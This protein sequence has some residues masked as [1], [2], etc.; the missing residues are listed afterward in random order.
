MNLC[1][2]LRRTASEIGSYCVYPFLYVH[3]AVI[4][5]YSTLCC[6]LEQYGD[7][8]RKHEELCAAYNTLHGK[9]ITLH[10]TATYAHD[11]EKE[12]EWFRKRFDATTGHI[13]PVMGVHC[14]ER[15]H[16]MLIEGG[17][18]QGFEKDMIVLADNLL[19]GKIT[20]VYPWYSVVQLITDPA[21]CVSVC[22]VG[23]GAHG[24]VRG[25]GS[26]EILHLER[27]D[28]LSPV[29]EQELL[30]S[31]GDGLVVPR[32]Y[33]VG[34]VEQY[35]SDGLYYTG[36]VKVLQRMADLKTCLVFDRNNLSKRS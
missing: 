24:I 20:A 1:G 22:G 3:T 10:A 33:G 9:Y 16:T 32:G 7:L 15:Q 11:V 8:L 27:V 23:S 5:P 19:V 6:G 18:R 21:S 26:P 13:V 12:L 29:Q 25:T 36:S 4:K 17:I 34:L 2:S 28:H 30:L 35:S 31:S 14:S